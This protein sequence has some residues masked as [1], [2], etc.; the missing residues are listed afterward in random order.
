M[1][2]ASV[3]HP[4]DHAASKAIFENAVKNKAPFETNRRLKS[5]KGVYNWFMTR[6]TPIIDGDGNLTCFYGT[7]TDINDQR[8]IQRE[9]IA[10]PGSNVLF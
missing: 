7:C 6:G 3:V 2:S 1:F 10:L 5:S 9:L 8:E 4:E